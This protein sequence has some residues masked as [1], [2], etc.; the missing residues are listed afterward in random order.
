MT[1]V[2]VR[3]VDRG[4]R[5]EWLRLRAE[6]W[7]DHLPEALVCEVD[8]YLAGAG[9][10]TFGTDSIPF[11]VLVAVRPDTGIVGFLEVSLRPWADK[12]RTAPVGY[13]EGWYVRPGWR[14]QGIGGTLVR[15]AEAWARSRG[16]RE[17][18]SDAHVD[19]LLSERS[20][21]ALGYEEAQRLI[22][23]RRDLPE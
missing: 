17:M 2:L 13:L 10:W 11:L 22:H 12:C 18:A 21:R 6:L 23:F 19:N 7:P 15:A 4:D 9:L 5:E 16:C 8:S 1:E 14:R 20:H 3:P